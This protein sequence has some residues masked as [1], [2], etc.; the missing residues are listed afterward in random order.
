MPILESDINHRLSGGA[1]NVDPNLALGGVMSG[2]GGG[3]IITDE[4]N[5]D[6]DDI[7]STEALLGIIIYHGYYYE[8]THA[9]LDLT[10]PVFWIDSQT[11]SGDTGVEIAIADEAK[12]VAIQTI[13]DEETAPSGPSFFTPL[14]KA[15]GLSI[16]T[17]EP[18]DNRGHWVRYSVSAEAGSSIDSYTIKLEGDT[19]E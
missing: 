4:D 2:V 14:N 12:N 18:S 13:A 19:L 15:A 1:T 5:N 7:T 11:S 8:N 10:L 17:L 9:T 16:G 6:M 3:I